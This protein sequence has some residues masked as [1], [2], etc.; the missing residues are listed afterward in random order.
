MNTFHPEVCGDLVA[1]SSSFAPFLFAAQEPGCY[2]S[3][4]FPSDISSLLGGR[5]MVSSLGVGL[6]LGRHGNGKREEGWQWLGDIPVTRS[7]CQHR[8][9]ISGCLGKLSFPGPGTCRCLGAL[10]LMSGCLGCNPR[11]SLPSITS[12]E[13]RSLTCKMGG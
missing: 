1:H 10:G 12:L 8:A 13:L 7:G 3:S 6:A 2:C 4:F 9:G 5:G 11:I